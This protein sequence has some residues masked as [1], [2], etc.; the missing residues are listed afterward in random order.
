MSALGLEQWFCGCFRS[1]AKSSTLWALFRLHAVFPEASLVCAWGMKS[2]AA[3][4]WPRHDFQ[5]LPN[6]LSIES[7]PCGSTALAVDKSNCHSHSKDQTANL[8]YVW[9]LTGKE[10]LQAQTQ[11]IAIS[12][13][14]THAWCV[15]PPLR[16]NG[17][18][19]AGRF[20][21]SLGF[22]CSTCHRNLLKN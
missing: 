5:I 13:S 20:S 6:L 16:K 18:S 7:E 2:P 9:V 17:R 11:F 19:W 21:K 4:W 12:A 3:F 22:G 1:L 15:H 8:A 14:P 10:K